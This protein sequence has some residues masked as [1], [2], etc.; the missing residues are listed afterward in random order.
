MLR[1]VMAA[2]ALTL[3]AACGEQTPSGGGGTPAA[4][5][6]KTAQ[7]GP[8]DFQAS[9]TLD[10]TTSDGLKFGDFY[11][12]CGATAGKGQTVSVQYTG[13]LTSGSKFDSSRDRGQPFTFQLGAGQVIKGW[14]EGVAGMQ[15]GG[16][17]RLEIPAA[18]GYG[19]QGYPP[20]IPA[21]ATLVFDVELVSISNS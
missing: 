14:D 7:T 13:W 12:G 2:M 20:V 17:R 4:A 3:L 10:Q 11:K 15:V 19:P 18:L 8:D 1:F 16:K 21:G 6:N 9:I 5:C